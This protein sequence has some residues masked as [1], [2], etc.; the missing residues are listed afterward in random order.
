MK[1]ILIVGG[2]VIA[3]LIGGTVW[4]QNLQMSDPDIISRSGIHWHPTLAIYVKDIQQEIPANIGIGPQYAGTPGYDPK[5]RMAAVHTHDASGVIHLEF[6]SGPV[7]KEDLTLG[8]F[9][10]IWGKDIRSFG[11]NMRMTVNGKENT[12]YENYNMKDGDKIELHYE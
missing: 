5:M 11:T 10:E 7:R 8:Q 2:I 1:T 9:F 6:M 4:S 12:E 3:L